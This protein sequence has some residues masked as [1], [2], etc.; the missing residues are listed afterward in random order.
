MEIKQLEYFVTAH[1]C[2]SLSK[3]AAQLFTT[4]PTV[5]RVIKLFEQDSG[6]PLFE[7]TSQGLKL[8]E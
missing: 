8:T 1:N 2:G 4:Q 6:S 3:A 7:R 5:S